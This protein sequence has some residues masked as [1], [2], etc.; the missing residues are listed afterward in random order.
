MKS[1]TSAVECTD[2]MVHFGTKINVSRRS[3]FHHQRLSKTDELPLY[4]F[5]HS[6]SPGYQQA[7]ARLCKVPG[8]STR[9]SFAIRHSKFSPSTTFENRRTAAVPV[10][11]LAESGYPQAS[12][13]LCKVPGDSDPASSR[14]RH[15]TFDIPKIFL[16]AGAYSLSWGRGQGEGGRFPAKLRYFPSIVHLCN[17]KREAPK[18]RAHSRIQPVSFSCVSENRLI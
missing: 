2:K 16:G 1:V 11:S 9:T 17:S 10:R 5:G 3:S 15:S 7:S 14:I 18:S 12:A 13:R 8:N 4:R 6:P